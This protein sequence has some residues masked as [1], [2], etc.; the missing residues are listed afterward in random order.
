MDAETGVLQQQIDELHQQIY[1]EETKVKTLLNK[2]LA[3]NDSKS[4]E[5]NNSKNPHGNNSPSKAKNAHGNAGGA[6]GVGVQS[7]QEK[8]KLL[9]DLNSKVRDCMHVCM[10]LYKCSMCVYGCFHEYL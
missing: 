3:D 8:E 4:A 9:A 7:Q 6:A 5:N 1:S 2:R 10:C